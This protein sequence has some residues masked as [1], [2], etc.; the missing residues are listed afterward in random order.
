MFSADRFRDNLSA[1]TINSRVIIEELTITAERN[2]DHADEIVLLVLDRLRKCL[3]KH[4]IFAFYLIDSICK[5]VGNPYNVMFSG[6][7]YSL[8]TDTY[9]VVTDTPTRQDLINLFKTWPRAR[10]S[11]GAELFPASVLK[12]IEL[13]VIDATSIGANVSGRIV[14]EM[15]LREANYL[16]QYVIT[17]DRDLELL[18]QRLSQ[19]AEFVTGCHRVRHKLIAEINAISEAVMASS[20][21]VFESRLR[22]YHESLQ[23]IRKLLDS[24]AHLQQQQMKKTPV[25]NGPKELKPPDFSMFILM[26]A[27][28]EADTVFRG[29]LEGWGRV[30][31]GR[32]GESGKEG[33]DKKS[34]AAARS[35]TGVMQSVVRD[36][37]FATNTEDRKEADDKRDDDG[38]KDDEAASP[39]TLSSSLGLTFSSASFMSSF[40]ETPT[41]KLVESETTK[42]EKSDQ[43]ETDSQPGGPA[44]SGLKR[45]GTGDGGVAKK[46]RF[47]DDVER[48]E[49]ELEWGEF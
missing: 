16:L 41:Y 43:M 46:V 6:H 25:D 32:T 24:Q 48:I 7:L 17:M 49:P 8:F 21:S 35:E 1:L 44:K 19:D 14:P 12:K 38:Q 3:P 4:K 15:L 31:H 36:L 5:N 39:D 34:E 33:K 23:Q 11:A 37:G 29:M 13:F 45:K 20:K 18:G 30:A 9:L 28:P 26:T 27:G 42:E 2:P 40:L 10:T 47:S 22:T